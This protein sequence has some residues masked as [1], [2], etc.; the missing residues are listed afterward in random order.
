LK[1]DIA[2]KRRK[3]HKNKILELMMA[4]TA[5]LTGIGL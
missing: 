5:E 3:K 4:P 1:I 2:A